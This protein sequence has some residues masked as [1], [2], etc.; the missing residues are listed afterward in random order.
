M[1]KA[2][3]RVGIGQY[4]HA[5]GHDGVSVSGPKRS[6]SSLKQMISIHVSDG[7]VMNKANLDGRQT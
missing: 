1:T 6:T 2:R 7:D 3:K 5:A 4:V